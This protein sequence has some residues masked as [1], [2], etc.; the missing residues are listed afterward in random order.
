VPYTDL[1]RQALRIAW[2]NRW[3][4]LLA[5]FAAETGGGFSGGFRGGNPF[6]GATRTGR[7]SG[8]PDLTPAWHW[9]QDHA[10]LLVAAGVGLL[11]VWIVLFFV[12]CACAA[13]EVRGVSEIDAGRP[14]GLRLA[15]DLGRER[16]WPVVRLRL[17]LLVAG[18]AILLVFGLV[19]AAAVALG[20]EQ[21]WFA[22]LVVL[23]FAVALAFTALLVGIAFSVLLP[24]ALRAAALEGR[25]GLGALRR[26]Y[27]LAKARPGRV[28]ACWGLMVACQLAFGLALFLAAALV[29]VPALAAAAAAYAA[30]QLAATVIAAVFFGIVIGGA[31]LVASAAFAAFYSSFWTLAYAR[32]ETT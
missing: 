5:F 8:L 24:V 1:L 23:Y 30:G 11:V 20:L 22:L 19:A 9:V 14:S 3:L 29:A 4:W 21:S 32:L 12:S 13:A 18:L 26:A 7:V 25:P 2:R 27:E 15:W 28:I 17:A 16:F 6:P 10:A 31:V